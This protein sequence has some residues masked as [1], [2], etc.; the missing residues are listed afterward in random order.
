M[1]SFSIVLPNSYAGG[2]VVKLHLCLVAERINILEILGSRY[3]RCEG[4]LRDKKMYVARYKREA[5]LLQSLRN[6]PSQKIR[7]LQ[8]CLPSSALRGE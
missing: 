7:K 8:R 2:G 5:T 3:C 4:G 6:V 1:T